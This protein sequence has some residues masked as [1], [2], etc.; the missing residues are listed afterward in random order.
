MIENA[1]SLARVRGVRTR[2]RPVRR[3]RRRRLLFP[4][5]SAPACAGVHG[6]FAVD[7]RAARCGH[8]GARLRQE[9]A[10]P[11]AAERSR[12]AHRRRRDPA[13]EHPGRATSCWRSCVSSASR[14][15]R[16]TRPIAAA[17]SSASCRTRRAWAASACWSSRIRRAMHPSVLEELR[18]LAAAE[19]DGVRVL[20]VLLL[21]QPSLNLVLESPRMA[22][23]VTANAPRFSLGPLSEDQT[24]AYVAHRLRAAGA[25]ESGRADAVHADVAHPCVQR[26][27]AGSHQ[28]TVCARAR[29]GC[30]R[31]RT[32]G[33]RPRRSTTRSKSSAGTTSGPPSPALRSA[34][35]QRLLQ[36]P[37]RAAS[38]SSRCRACRIVR[39]R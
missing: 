27:R 29:V 13:R 19:V 37:R 22:E 21:G 15:K 24:A 31:R 3:Q 20:K 8:R 26:R 7:Q 35:S 33:H 11:P 16:P 1:R 25:V 28:Q 18:C 10:D 38:S 32:A 5:R 6:A 34:M 12:R 30:L 17:A 39:S 14:S 36:H 4:Q 2:D 9:P 23:L